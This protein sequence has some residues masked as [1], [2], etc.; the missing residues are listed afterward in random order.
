MENVAK[1]SSN[2]KRLLISRIANSESRLA[3]LFF[4]QSDFH[5]SDSVKFQ[6][7]VVEKLNIPVI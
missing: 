6:E 2:M 5:S 1:R 4:L 7:L 3:M